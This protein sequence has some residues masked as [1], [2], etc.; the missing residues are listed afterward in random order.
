MLEEFNSKTFL[1]C[2]H[3][4]FQIHVA[5]HE[6]LTVELIEVSERNT[7]PQLEQFSLFF[8]GPASPYALQ[9]THQMEHEKLG[10]FDLFLVPLGPDALGMRYEAVFNRFRK[11]GEVA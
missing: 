4:A 6:P 8:R 7:S 2:L 5:G 1:E 11:S 9:A 10:R 3:T